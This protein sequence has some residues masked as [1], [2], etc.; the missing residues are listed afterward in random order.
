MPNS[1]KDMTGVVINNLV[2]I[3]DAGKVASRSRVWICEC[4]I[5][6]ERVERTVR[7]SHY[8]DIFGMTGCGEHRSARAIQASENAIPQDRRDVLD[9]RTYKEVAD[10]LG[11]Q[12]RSL[13]RRL[14]RGW[15]PEEAMS[16]KK[17]R[18]W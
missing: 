15:D 7:D 11:I 5:C 10:E 18:D 8:R 9:G 13:K 16:T 1:R 2:F 3:E 17:L 6:G 4:L 12:V 14:R